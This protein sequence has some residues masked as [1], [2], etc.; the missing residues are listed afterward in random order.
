MK[1]E[2]PS[3]R[4]KAAAAF[5]LV[6]LLVVLAVLAALLT[7]V[8]PMFGRA[9]ELTRSATCQSNLHHISSFLHTEE[10]PGLGLPGGTFHTIPTA[11]RWFDYLMDRGQPKLALC[12]SETSK[13]D[14]TWTLR[15]L[16]VRQDG[17]E[18]SDNPDIHYS[19]LYDLLNGIPVDDWQVG[20][21]YHGVQYGGS[22]EGWQWVEDLNGGP[23]EDNEAFV[24]IATCAAFRITIHEQTVD[25]TPLGH[26]PY[27]NSGSNHWVIKGEPDEDTWQN[28]VVV[29]LT[30]I[31]Q[32][33]ARPPVTVY[34]G[35]CHYGMSTRVP[36]RNFTLERLWM[37]EYSDEVMSLSNYHMDDPFDGDRENGE[38]LDRHLG[39]VNCN[40]VDGS[41]FRMT[42]DELED[43]FNK[44]DTGAENIFE[45]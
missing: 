27:W 1:H 22:Y 45:R 14:A 26:H 18:Y 30:G 3:C 35:D 29:E 32:P 10:N 12:P 6:E 9:I 37:L 38:V 41:V 42:K 5:T 25:V 39:Y 15:K 19:N 21:L 24:T 36:V 43:E 23:C 7:I 2:R 20:A 17:H 40:R 4:R 33:I 44:I 11:N 16:W 34:S 31:N 28:G 13:R 8:A